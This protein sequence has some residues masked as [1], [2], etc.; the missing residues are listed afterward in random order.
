MTIMTRRL[1]LNLLSLIVLH[2]L[3]CCIAPAF[4][5]TTTKAIASNS[6]SAAVIMEDMSTP[7]T[8]LTL[9]WE[10]QGPWHFEKDW[11]NKQH[12][13]MP[14]FIKNIALKSTLILD[15]ETQTYHQVDDKGQ[16]L[17]E[18]RVFRIVKIL[19]DAV[20]FLRK[21]KGKEIAFRLEQREDG[22]LYYCEGES[23]SDSM[24]YRIHRPPRHV[25]VQG[26]D[27]AG[28]DIGADTA[29]AVV[30]EEMIA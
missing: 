2:F 15:K 26:R 28:T 29:S 24:A 1:S 21:E 23:G 10:W 16:P 5:S 9:Q 20:H 3:G 17:K 18:A 14:R 13:W 22:Y 8:P 11:F 12:P 4:A 27:I 25:H 30:T 7:P 6:S 19:K